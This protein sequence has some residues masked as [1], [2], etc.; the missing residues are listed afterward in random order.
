MSEPNAQNSGLAW[1]DA[2]SSSV[3]VT[4]TLAIDRVASYGGRFEGI[5]K[6]GLNVS[7]MLDTLETRYG[8]CA[9]NISYNLAKLGNHAAPLA[10]VGDDF[11]EGYQQHLQEAG[12]DLSHVHNVPGTLSSCAT[13]FTDVDE[14]QFCGFYPGAASATS[15]EI[16]QQALQDAVQSQPW[17]YA[18][19][20]VDAAPR[21]LFA[22]RELKKA[23]VPTL[24]DPGQCITDFTP[25]ETRDVVAMSDTLILNE[26]EFQTAR[27][28]CGDAI[29]QVGLLIVTFG[30]R[31][32]AFGDD[33]IPS[34]PALAVVDPTGCGDAYRAGYL[35]ATLRGAETLDAVRAG[36]TA[37]C[38][39]LEHRGS[40]KHGLQEFAERFAAHWDYVPE[41]LPAPADSV[42]FDR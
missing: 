8:G 21:M 19:V 1:A 7:L 12:V 30:K 10:F 37:A 3:L 29:N 31:G 41:W 13:M 14:N 28:R 4:G 16:Y 17:D 34:A 36:T 24:C 5:P 38:I 32:S 35:D 25:A 6:R 27:E 22:L 42:E 15:Q 11:R 40:Q 18:V 26:H 39:N 33:L 23:G 9:G 2:A 20:S